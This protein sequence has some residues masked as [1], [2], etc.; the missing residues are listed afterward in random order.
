MKEG[1]IPI[2]DPKWQTTASLEEIRYI[3]R[4]DSENGPVPLLEERWASINEL[5]RF[6]LKE[7]GGNLVNLLKDCNRSAK[8]LMDKISKMKMWNDETNYKEQKLKV[9]KRIQVKCVWKNIEKHSC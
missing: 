4:E 7:C 3:F 6:T 1:K 9:F 5:G 8:V 2:L